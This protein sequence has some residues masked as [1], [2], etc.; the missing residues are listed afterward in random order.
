MT[1][2]D[3]KNISKAKVKSRSKD[4]NG[5]FIGTYNA[6]PLLNSILYDVEF[7]DGSIKQYSANIIAENIHSQ[8]DPEGFSTTLFDSIID[9]KSNSKT[10]PKDKMFVCTKSS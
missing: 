2:P 4:L 5:E 9:Y 3:G 8:V 6:N 7:E 1:L 10:V